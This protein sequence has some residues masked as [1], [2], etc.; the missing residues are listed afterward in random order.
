MNAG[1]AA[2][3]HPLG[4][5]GG[6][7]SRRARKPGPRSRKSLTTTRFGIGHIAIGCALSYL[8]FRFADGELAQ[9]SSSPRQLARRLRGAPIGAG[10]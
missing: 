2:V 6:A 4:E 7:E 5:Q 8:D 9:G 10:D 3:R 1:G